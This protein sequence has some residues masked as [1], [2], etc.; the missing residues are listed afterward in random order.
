VKVKQ[1]GRI[2]NRSIYLAVGVNLQGRKEVLGFWAAENEGAKFW[3]SVVYPIPSTG[4]LHRKAETLA[5]SLPGTDI[6]SFWEPYNTHFLLF[7]V[8][9]WQV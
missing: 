6:L 3:L 8:I 5:L 9:D 2:A 4:H 7:T 1:D